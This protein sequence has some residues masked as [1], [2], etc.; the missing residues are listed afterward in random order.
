MSGDVQYALFFPLMALFDIGRLSERMNVVSVLRNH[1]ST[2]P[3]SRFHLTRRR[4][5]TLLVWLLDSQLALV[6][7]DKPRKIRTEY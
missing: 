5:W 4:H 1:A 7:V 2:P 6:H 3:R